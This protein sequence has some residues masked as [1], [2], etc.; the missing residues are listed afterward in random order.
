MVLTQL[1][2][3]FQSNQQNRFLFPYHY[4]SHATQGWLES[5]IILRAVSIPLWFSR[6][7]KKER[8]ECYLSPVSIPLWFSRNASPWCE[9]L[10]DPLC[11]HTTM[12]LTQPLRTHRSH[13]G[14]HQFPYHY[15]SHATKVNPLTFSSTNA[16]FPYHYGS[17]AT[18]TYEYNPAAN[19]TRFHTTMV[20]TQH[21]TMVS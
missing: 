4:G 5:L 17:H 19:L 1:K 20:L 7:E 14:T 15:G 16:A 18:E 8:K 12:V 2:K 3:R 21:L 13:S 11:F 10:W 9:T 6:N